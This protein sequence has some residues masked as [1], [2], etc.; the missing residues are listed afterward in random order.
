MNRAPSLTRSPLSTTDS[1]HS[2]HAAC[3]SRGGSRGSRRRTGPGWL[4]T[5]LAVLGAS[6]NGSTSGGGPSPSQITSTTGPP[7]MGPAANASSSGALTP[8]AAADT[9]AAGA[10]GS[11]VEGVGS[12]GIGRITSAACRTTG[13]G[14]GAGQLTPTKASTPG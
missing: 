1:S 10:V 2:R 11:S 13:A 9:A 3:S 5:T 4:S 14:S 12:A 7:S 6:T 8:G